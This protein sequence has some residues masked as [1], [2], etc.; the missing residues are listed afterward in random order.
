MVHPSVGIRGDWKRTTSPALSSSYDYNW[1]NFSGKEKKRYV[2]FHRFLVS[3]PTNG[4]TT[5]ENTRRSGAGKLAAKSIW[6]C[7]TL[8]LLAGLAFLADFLRGRAVAVV[9][10]WFLVC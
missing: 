8:T 7:W 1:K 6:C 3:L 10:R 5:L 4:K 9:M 2:D